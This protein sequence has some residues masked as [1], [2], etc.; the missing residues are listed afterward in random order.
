MAFAEGLFALGLLW[1]LIA[2]WPSPPWDA[3][4]Y[5]G[6]A[7]M[8]LGADRA[9]P[10]L[11]ALLARVRSDLQ[12]AASRGLRAT[13][14]AERA[15]ARALAGRDQAGD[16]ALIARKSASPLAGFTRC[17]SKPARRL[18]ARSSAD[19]RLVRAMR[20]MRRPNASRKSL[21][22]LPAVQA[23]EADVDDGDGRRARPRHRERAQ[24]VARG[25][26]R[27]SDD[28]EP[29]REPGPAVLVILD[30]QNP[31]HDSSVHLVWEVGGARTRWWDAP[32]RFSAR[33]RAGRG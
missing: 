13:F 24:A 9:V 25:L 2:T 7:A 23:G 22:D 3:I 28:F 29:E 12:A 1:V 31:G 5:G 17:A 20:P 32:S 15:V 19:W 21:G 27:M 30:H 10:V 18:R 11:E 26:D 33:R 14:V 6:I 4:Y 8:V 16:S